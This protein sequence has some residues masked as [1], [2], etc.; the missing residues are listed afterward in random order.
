MAKLVSH[1]ELSSGRK[2]ALPPVH[3]ETAAACHVGIGSARE[4]KAHQQLELHQQD[5]RADQPLPGDPR[6][7]AAEPRFCGRGLFLGSAEVQ[8]CS[9]R[10]VR[11]PGSAHGIEL[12]DPQSNETPLSWLWRAWERNTVQKDGHAMY[13][14]RFGETVTNPNDFRTGIVPGSMAAVMHLLFAQHA[15]S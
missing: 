8:F 15:W 9:S 4:S 3:L 1:T 11:K 7:G 5:D 14:C 2:I 6:C 13:V 12:P 10:G